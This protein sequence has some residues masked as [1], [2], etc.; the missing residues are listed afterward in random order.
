MSGRSAP[1]P[2]YERLPPGPCNDPERVAAS[3]RE[4]LC[5]AMA[6][7]VALYGYEGMRVRGLCAL[8]AVAPNTLYRLFPGGLHECFLGAQE[9]ALLCA[10]RRIAA[11][12]SN[13]TEP[14]ARLRLALEGLG[15]LVAEEPRR[16]YLVLLEAPVVSPES[17][18]RSRSAASRCAAVLAQLLGWPSSNVSPLAPAVVAGVAHVARRLL[19]DDR[20]DELPGVAGELASWAVSCGERAM[21]PRLSGQRC[22]QASGPSRGVAGRALPTSSQAQDEHSRL[23]SA[24]IELLGAR[25]GSV[26]CAERLAEHALVP[27]RRVEALFGGWRPC[28][29]AAIE[30][31]VARLLERSVAIAGDSV[32]RQRAQRVLVATLT[33]LAVDRPLARAMFVQLPGLGREGMRLREALIDSLAGAFASTT[34][35]SYGEEVALGASA[36]AVWGAIEHTLG[37]EDRARL[38][39]VADLLTLI[40][41]NATSDPGQQRLSH[42]RRAIGARPALA[43]ATSLG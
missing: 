11:A 27:K 17:R 12:Q 21:A 26:L 22:R 14:V 8:A 32:G 10:G 19:L 7:G 40:A 36:G 25:E 35:G 28:A 20:A 30:H 2:L 31:G 29:L 5:G 23:M 4:R 3:Q 33:G 9:Q 18:E 15:R 42:A 13:E 43:S 6:H 41:A 39:T 34:L 24:A 16:A 1:E 37:A 38:P